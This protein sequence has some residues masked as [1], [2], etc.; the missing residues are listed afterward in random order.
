M[1]LT[2]NYV[3][4]EDRQADHQSAVIGVEGKITTQVVS[5]LIDPGSI[6]SYVTPKI[7]ENCSL[8][9]IKHSKTWF[10][11]LVIGTKRMVIEIAASFSLEL[12]GLSFY[13][14]LNV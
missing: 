10:I 11:Q 12:N 1:H 7:V 13:A 9:Q 2:E 3:V 6:H 14:N 5:I 8:N 4:L